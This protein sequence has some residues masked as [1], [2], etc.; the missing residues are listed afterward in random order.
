VVLAALLKLALSSWLAVGV[1]RLAI[2]L[3]H[4]H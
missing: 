2:M 1:V 4:L 3:E